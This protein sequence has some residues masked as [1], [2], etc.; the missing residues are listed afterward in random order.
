MNLAHIDERGARDAP[1][2][3]TN[4]PGENIFR[5]SIWNAVSSH[6]SGQ[7]GREEAKHRSRQVSY[8]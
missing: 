4:T 1:L 3:C 2:N 7:S 6:L 5:S 8:K